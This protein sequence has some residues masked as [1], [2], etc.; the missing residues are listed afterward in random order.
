MNSISGRLN[1][2][3]VTFIFLLGWALSIWIAFREWDIVQRDAHAWM[4]LLAVFYPGPWLRMAKDKFANWKLAGLSYALLAM[5]L[6]LI[7]QLAPTVR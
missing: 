2:I 1:L 6:G 7:V 3:G 5:A 4:I